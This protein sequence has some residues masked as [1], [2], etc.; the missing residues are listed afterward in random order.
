MLDRAVRTDRRHGLYAVLDIQLARLAE[1]AM[2]TA[3]NGTTKA[4]LGVPAFQDRRRAPVGRPSPSNYRGHA[5]VAGYNIMNEPAE[6][7]ATDQAVLRPG[8]S[9]PSVRRDPDKIILLDGN[10]YATDF[11]RLRECSGHPNTVYT[12]QDYALAGLRWTGRPYSGRTR[13]GVLSTRGQWWRRLSC[14]GH[15]FMRSNARAVWSGG[16]SRAGVHR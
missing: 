5:T 11:Q 16:V 15:E 9:R 10:R 7:A 4:R 2:G 13:G 14:G 12:A 8:Y 3:T 1:P 6:T